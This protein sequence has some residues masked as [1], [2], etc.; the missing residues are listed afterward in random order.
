M[1]LQ[2]HSRRQ[3]ILAVRMSLTSDYYTQEAD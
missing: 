1:L 3:E 2:A